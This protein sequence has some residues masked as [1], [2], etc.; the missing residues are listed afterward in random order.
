MLGK[1]IKFKSVGVSDE[2][3]HIVGGHEFQRKKFNLIEKPSLSF[4]EP[5]IF[6][7]WVNS[8]NIL[9]IILCYLFSSFVILFNM[10]YLHAANCS[11]NSSNYK[12]MEVEL[13][14]Q[15]NM[16]EAL[17]IQKVYTPPR[18]VINLSDLATCLRDSRE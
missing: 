14:I 8:Y 12:K 2:F 4:L 1:S 18:I 11:S 3:S 6:I 9:S 10:L 5:I 15:T 16:S 7:I 17:L 13:E